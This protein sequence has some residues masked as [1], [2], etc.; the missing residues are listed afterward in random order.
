MNLREQ[1]NQLRSRIELAIASE[2]IQRQHL[3]PS[4]PFF[5]GDP[6]Y[7]VKLNK[8]DV[9]YGSGEIDKIE[10]IW[11]IVQRDGSSLMFFG[12]PFESAAFQDTR[13][14]LDG[15]HPGDYSPEALLSILDAVKA[16]NPKPAEGVSEAQAVPSDAEINSVLSASLSGLIRPRK[17]EAGS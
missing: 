4:H 10:L 15:T 1:Y 8:L 2:L 3:Q 7:G 14:D 11:A 12:H 9:P 16:S 5:G 13:R 17:P 6:V